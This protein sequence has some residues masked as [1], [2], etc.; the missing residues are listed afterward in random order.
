LNSLERQ[1]E[2]LFEKPLKEKGQANSGKI[3][4]VFRK[5]CS[6]FIR[7]MLN[8]VVKDVKREDE[9]NTNISLIMP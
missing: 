1:P 6:K 4:R 7:G 9:I 3:Y 8:L 2:E 5:I